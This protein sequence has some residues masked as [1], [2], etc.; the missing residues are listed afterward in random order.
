LSERP[1]RA[2]ELRVMT[3]E[4]VGAALMVGLGETYIA[5]FALAVGLGAVGAGLLATLP[6]LTGG[7]IQLLT[8]LGTRALRSNRRW[9]MACAAVQVLSF[10]PLV[11]GALRG[12]L[13]AWALFATSVV[14][15]AGGMGVG[16][17]WQQWASTLVPERIRTRYFARRTR[18]V[19][20]ALS[21]GV[22]G[23]GGLLWL[24]GDRPTA[25]AWTFTLAALA[26]LFSLAMFYVQT[27]PRIEPVPQTHGTDVGRPH[28]G[29]LFGYLL[30]VVFFVN[31]S[32]PYFTPYML[33]HLALSRPMFALLIGSA[34]VARILAM[35]LLGRW[36]ERRGARHLLRLAGL[37]ITPLPVLWLLASHPLWLLVIQVV[38]GVAWGAYELATLLLFFDTLAPEDRVKRLTQFNLANVSALAA[39]SAVGAVILSN[40]PSPALGYVVLFLVSSAG[41]AISLRWMRAIQ[42]DVRA[43]APPLRPLAVRPSFGS[44]DRPIFPPS[45]ET[46]TLA[47][48]SAAD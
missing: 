21:A 5:A 7:V 36:T 26:R 15:W 6:M 39:G 9:A 25:F 31:I 10:V 33:D 27:E 11:L 23:A 29:H 45:K 44:L 32:G 16:P 3:L 28:P 12:A 47:S 34:L 19:Q 43:P 37:C 4:G 1:D 40:A 13:P 30:S 35:P 2:V 8:P 17:A 42:I 20:A 38:S 18:L 41:R 14:Y 46:E 48:E 24:A 22:F